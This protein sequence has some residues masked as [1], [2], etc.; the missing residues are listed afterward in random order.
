MELIVIFF[1]NAIAYKKRFS[2]PIFQRQPEGSRAI[3][4]IFL[5]GIPRPQLE[6]CD[7][8]CSSLL[9]QPNTNSS[10]KSLVCL[11]VFFN[12]RCV[13]VMHP[14]G[15]GMQ[16]IPSLVP[17]LSLEVPC[18]YFLMFIFHSG[19]HWSGLARL[20]MPENL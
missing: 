2:S 20:I 19:R 4:A 16:T 9:A 3:A 12:E 7:L 5:F 11:F 13:P 1:V 8:R 6:L 17:I 10:S 18:H 15:S 14:F